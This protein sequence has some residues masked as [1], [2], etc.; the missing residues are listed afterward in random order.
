MS[1]Q[2]HPSAST[3]P[4][5]LV[6]RTARPEDLSAVSAVNRAAYA[7]YGAYLDPERIARYLDNAGDVWSRLDSAEL[8]VAELD[9]EIVGSLTYYAPGPRS[10]AQGW[11]PTWAGLRLLAVAPSARGRGVGRALMEASIARARADGAEAIA[12]HTTEMMAIARA[13]YERMGFVRDPEHDYV[14][15]SGGRGAMAYRLDL[16]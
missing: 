13:M 14:P 9:G 5:S 16:T 8:L 15:R 1:D 11:P 12:L 3:P 6:I 2:P 7:E 10:E 4:A